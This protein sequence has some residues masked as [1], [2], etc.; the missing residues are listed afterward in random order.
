IDHTRN[1]G[2]DNRI[3]SPSLHEKRD[4]YVYLPPGYD[5]SK[6]YPLAIYL[7]GINQDEIG[8]I[9]DVVKPLDAAI[10]CGKLPPMIIAAPDVSLK[11]VPCL[12]TT[13]TFFLNSN[14]GAFEDY[15]VFDVYDFLMSN[16]P[17][18]PEPE[19]H[20]LIGASMGGG[21]AFAK[22]IKYPD[23]FKV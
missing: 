20:V 16:Y 7:H 1:H 23:R 4:L 5:P 21:A 11:G 18:R 15:L 19:A 22:A 8:F 6:K 2:H 3:Y 17:I 9:D 13:G 12:I 14:L 10:A